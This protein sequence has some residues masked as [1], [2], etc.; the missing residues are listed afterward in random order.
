MAGNVVVDDVEESEIEQGPPRLTSGWIV[1]LAAAVGF[2]LLLLPGRSDGP[3]T[4]TTV[5]V[6]EVVLEEE[7]WKPFD[8][9][10][11]GTLT[12]ITRL[13]DDRYVAV[14]QG[15][16]MW[17]HDG[18]AVWE[19]VSEQETTYATVSAVAAYG[20]G[21]VAVGAEHLDGELTEAAIWKAVDARTWQRIPLQALRPSGL[22]GIVAAGRRLLAWGWTGS[23]REFNPDAA[24]L[25]LQSDD[26]ETWSPVPPFDGDGGSARLLTVTRRLDTWYAGGY[27]TGRAAL[28]QS[29][30]DLD[31]WSPIDTSDLPFGW[32]IIGIRWGAPGDA[33]ALVATLLHLDEGRARR[34][35]LQGGDWT[36]IEE[37]PGELVV[38]AD[39]AAEKVGVGNGTLWKWEEPGRWQAV[40][41]EGQVTSV[42]GRIAVGSTRRGEPRIWVLE[43]TAEQEAA[44]PRGEGGRWK[45]LQELP[46]ADISGVWRVADGWVVGGTPGRWMF[47]GP[48]GEET[49]VPPWGENIHAI[50]GVGDEWVALPSMHWSDDGV[51]WE[52]RTRPWEDQTTVPTVEAVT[53]VDGRLLAV[54][55]DNQFLW[56]V[57]VSDDGG[58]TW[59]AFDE[60]APATPV[61]NVTGVPGGFV[62]TA[63]RTQEAESVV[64]S[65]DGRNWETVE[66]GSLIPGAQP[67]A[68]LTA[69]GR[70][71]L[72]DRDEEIEPPRTDIT[73]LARADDGLLVV[74][75]GSM[76]RG[77]EGWEEIPLDPPHG[78]PA[79]SVVPA[80]LGERLLAI[81]FE[82]EGRFLY[83][84]QP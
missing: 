12:D 80:P 21:A 36:P 56:N 38:P 46:V 10:G 4:S 50:V 30:T 49:F 33:S 24:P 60:P 48:E 16:Q 71:L 74:A 9:P 19:W 57:A 18:A 62:A 5:G 82:G 55:H 40:D 8:L 72:F 84:W 45:T 76:W 7:R 53:E 73:A 42:D 27:E 43:G 29:G 59:S 35:M 20:Q 2:I 47:L 22:D 52:E 34:W 54:G 79:G 32:G 81:G 75:G 78:M 28:W 31:N 26:G 37:R 44:L 51:E 70:L 15:P 17:L 39:T 23:E 1:G 58:H 83:E 6:P 64:K 13:T 11:S 63:A 3:A 66:R 65:T 68:A 69:D 77:G 41:L 14:G 67:P 61:W 25:M